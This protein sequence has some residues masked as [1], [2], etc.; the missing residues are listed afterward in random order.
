MYIGPQPVSFK[1]TEYEPSKVELRK[2][3]YVIFDYQIL[4]AF[5]TMKKL[6]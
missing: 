4:R 5:F 6:K 2:C 1:L 3:Q